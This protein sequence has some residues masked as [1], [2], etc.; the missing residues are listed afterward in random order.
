MKEEE[1]SVKE[2]DGW[3]AVNEEGGGRLS[4]TGHICFENLRSI[5]T[6]FTPVL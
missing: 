1:L 4:V 2:G 5:D 6:G 3:R